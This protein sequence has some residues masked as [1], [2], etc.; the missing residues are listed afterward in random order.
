MFNLDK[1]NRVGVGH[2]PDHLGIVLTHAAN[3]GVRAMLAKQPT[4]FPQVWDAPLRQPV[5]DKTLALFRY[6]QMILYPKA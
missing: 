5:T 4:E 3:G 2:L 6:T 1:L